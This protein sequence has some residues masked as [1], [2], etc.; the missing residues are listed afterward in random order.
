MNIVKIQNK[1]YVLI[2]EAELIRL[3]TLAAKKSKTAKKLSFAE[4]KK[5]A[6]KL[7]EKWHAEGS[8]S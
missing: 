7:V 3:Q 6:Y 2:E 8:R 5:R 1:K 4:G